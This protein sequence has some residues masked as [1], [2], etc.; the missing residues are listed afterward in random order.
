MEQDFRENLI[1][2]MNLRDKIKPLTALFLLMEYSF[3][4]LQSDIRKLDDPKVLIRLN[5]RVNQANQLLEY[6]R[7]DTGRKESHPN[8]DAFE[9]SFC[10]FKTVMEILGLSRAKVESLILD[11]VIVPIQNR[12]GEKRR[13][14]KKVILNYRAGLKK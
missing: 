7:Q 9:N 5:A 2:A 11:K 3:D 12:P 8:P 1:E 6:H 14:D 4:E 10:D 13:F